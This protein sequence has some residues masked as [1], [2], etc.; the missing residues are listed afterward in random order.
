MKT[1]KIEHYGKTIQYTNKDCV[2]FVLDMENEGLEVE[3]YN[4]RYFWKGPAVRVD[5]IQEVLSNTKVLCQWDNMGLGY[6]VYPKASDE[7][8]DVTDSKD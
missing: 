6:V 3:H 4:G 2:K 1:A 5:S 7:G 8:I